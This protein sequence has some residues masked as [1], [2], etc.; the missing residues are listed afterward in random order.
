MDNGVNGVKNK[1][2]ET[3]GVV[4]IPDASEIK[5][6]GCCLFT[7]DQGKLLPVNKI[8]LFFLFMTEILG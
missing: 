2:K 4:S 7:S 5:E 3:V 6:C 8:E 1:K